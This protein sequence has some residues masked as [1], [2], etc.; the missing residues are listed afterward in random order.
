MSRN[1]AAVVTSPDG[2][3]THELT[4]YL[5]REAEGALRQYQEYAWTGYVREINKNSS[6]GIPYA[7]SGDKRQARGNVFIRRAMRRAGL[8]LKAIPATV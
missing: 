8:H 6:L 1:F 2:A 4:Y 5:R 7:D 3:I